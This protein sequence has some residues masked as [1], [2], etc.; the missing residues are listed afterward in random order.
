[1]IPPVGENLILGGRRWCV[2]DIQAAARSVFV[3]PAKGGKAPVFRGAGGEIH[4]RIVEEMRAVLTDSDEPPYL[5]RAAQ[6]LLKAA[7]VMANRAA[8][9]C[10]GYIIREESVQWFPGWAPEVC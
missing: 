3:V 5:D 8:V 10:P 7:R 6:M 2:N 1:L 4:N 9:L